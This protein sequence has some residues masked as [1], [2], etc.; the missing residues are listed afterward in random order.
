M[1][2]CFHESTSSDSPDIHPSRFCNR[3]YLIIRKT[4]GS[5]AKGT[6]YNTSLKL[7][8]W[9]KHQEDTCRTCDMVAGRKAGGRLN[10]FGFPSHLIKHIHSIAGPKY[11][12]SKPLT[13]DRF[14]PLSPHVPVGV[15]IGD[16]TCIVCSNVLDEAIELPCKH[17]LCSPCCIQV[18]NSTNC[19]EC[20]TCKE[21]HEV[22]Q[23]SF[24]PPSSLTLKFMEQLVLH[25]D[26]GCKQEVYLNDTWKATANIPA[27]STRFWISHLMHPPHNWK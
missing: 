19:M 20:P 3:C 9:E 25:C 27:A 14:L 13:L 24:L 15:G 17:S 21:N 7:H 8:T 1:E 10:I 6:V 26:R 5:Y 22:V 11:R 12:Y 18:V 2:E 23:S 16:F 4:R